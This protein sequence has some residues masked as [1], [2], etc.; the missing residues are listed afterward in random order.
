[1]S[2]ENYLQASEKVQRGRK[3]FKSHCAKKSDLSTSHG[4]LKASTLQQCIDEVLHCHALMT[5]RKTDT[6]IRT[7]R[8]LSCY[9]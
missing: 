5:F 4:T 2:P 6:E 8:T 9:R 7:L 3:Q 1:M